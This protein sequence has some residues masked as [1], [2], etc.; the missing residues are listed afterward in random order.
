LTTD[1]AVA[2]GEIPSRPRWD[3]HQAEKITATTAP[4]I[5]SQRSAVREAFPC[6]RFGGWDFEGVL[7]ALAMPPEFYESR[8]GGKSVFDPASSTKARWRGSFQG[9]R[10]GHH[11]SPAVIFLKYDSHMTPIPLVQ[12][13]DSD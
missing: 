10:A 6:P 13:P 8:R 4:A 5:A 2:G 9:W 11:G 3:R 12:M 7:R 1:R